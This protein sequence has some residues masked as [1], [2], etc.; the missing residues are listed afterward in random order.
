MTKIT[1]VGVQEWETK[2]KKTNETIK[3][4][5]YIGFL[6][7]NKAIKFTSREIYATNEGS[8]QFDPKLAIEVDL[9]VK[10]FKGEITYQ[11]RSSF[12]TK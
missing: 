11:D 3:G 10:L 8:I 2:D 4:L 6:P 5:S 12:G 1:I 7:D 9:G